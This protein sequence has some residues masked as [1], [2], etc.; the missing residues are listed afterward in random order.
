MA[1]GTHSPPDGF[2][3]RPGAT[4]FDSYFWNRQAASGIDPANRSGGG[5]G[6]CGAGGDEMPTTLKSAAEGYLRARSLSRGARNEYLTTLRKWEQWGGGVPLEELRRKD[7]REFLDWVYERAVTDE[8]TNPGRTANK[9]REHL[10]AILS[11]ALEQELIDVPPGSPGPGTSA[12]WSAAT[13]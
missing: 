2:R 8:G 6:S 12:T 4:P 10:R 5:A 9:A 13:T 3:E 7:I 1:Q 11:W